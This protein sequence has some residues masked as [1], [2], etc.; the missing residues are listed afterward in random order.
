MLVVELVPLH[1]ASSAPDAQVCSPGT[2]LRASWQQDHDTSCLLAT[3]LVCPVV[4]RRCLH[5]QP[6][7]TCSV[8][9]WGQS[10]PAWVLGAPAPRPS[11]V[12]SDP[13][14]AAGACGRRRLL[15]GLLK[16]RGCRRE[17]RIVLLNMPLNPAVLL[18]PKERDKRACGYEKRDQRSASPFR[19]R[20]GK[21]ARA[22]PFLGGELIH[23]GFCEPA[24]LDGCHAPPVSTSPQASPLQLTVGPPEQPTSGLGEH[25]AR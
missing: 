2:A 25:P 11:Q 16:A 14:C 22:S 10:G 4:L 18:R 23:G 8:C 17:R 7:Q 12:E 20:I 6:P 1:A 9:T 15:L 24:F 3:H 21:I 19:E 13:P 5:L